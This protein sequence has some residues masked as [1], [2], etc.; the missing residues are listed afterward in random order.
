[1][2]KTPWSIP[3]SPRIDSTARQ[4]DPRSYMWSTQVTRSWT[5][6]WNV[7]PKRWTGSR[8]GCS[9]SVPTPVLLKEH[10][11]VL[12]QSVSLFAAYL[13]IEKWYVVSPALSF[14]G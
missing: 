5:G 10:D 1:M 2:L 12:V 3:L 7:F 8:T 4:R 9:A 14:S 6:G 11:F 13:Y